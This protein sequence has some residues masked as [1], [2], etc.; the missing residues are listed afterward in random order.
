M[1]ARLELGLDGLEA[2]GLIDGVGRR[3]EDRLNDAELR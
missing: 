2:L 3:R 1:Q